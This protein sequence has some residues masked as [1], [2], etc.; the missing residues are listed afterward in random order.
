MTD[1]SESFRVQALADYLKACMQAEE[2]R[3]V[4]FSR[5]SGGAIQDNFGVTVECRGGQWEGRHELVVR[6]DAPSKVAVSLSRAQE[7]RVLQVAHEAGVTVP[8]P[9][10]CCEDPS[11]IGVPFWVMSR[12]AGSASARDLVRQMGE[13]PERGR[14]LVRH[15]GRELAR[16]HRVIPEPQIVDRLNFLKLPQ[17]QPSLARV[18]E[19]RAALDAIPRPHPVLEWALNWLESR[20]VDSG[21]R[22][23][24]HGDFRSGNYMVEDGRVSAVLDWEFAS[25]GDPYEDLGW[26][27]ARSWRFGAPEREVG[28]VGLRQDLYASWE[29]ETGHKVDDHQVRYWEVMGMV[30]W[31]I[32]ALQQGQRHLSGEQPSLELALTGRMLPE[33]EL[34]ALVTIMQIEG[35]PLSAGDLAPWQTDP[36]RPAGQSSLLVPDSANA[37]NIARQTLLNDLLPTLP[38]SQNYAALMVANAMAAA[39]REL[40]DAGESSAGVQRA[41]RAFLDEVPQAQ[42]TLSPTDSV[43]PEAAQASANND[44]RQ[45]LARALRRQ[46]IP[47]VH[48]TALRR[49]L[50]LDTCTRLALSNPK[51]LAAHQQGARDMATVQ[52]GD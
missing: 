14:A 37:L 28:G 19:Y 4:A 20:A 25:F 31:A 7:F 33:I 6:S 18:R 23:L 50:I 1:S 29:A 51:Y 45:T 39:M 11:V 26:L 21:L 46:A 13:H 2:V 52:S 9:L 27:C 40:M 36:A 10:W 16:I 15:L 3:V 38:K 22:T 43:N 34:D 5:L 47:V 42:A 48:E 32:I 41:V 49:L 8:H 12:V 35:R 24:C 17:E 30:R 44:P